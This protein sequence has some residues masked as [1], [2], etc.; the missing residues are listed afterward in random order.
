MMIDKSTLTKIGQ[1]IKPHGIS[2]EI[3][4]NFSLTLDDNFPKYFI[5]EDEGI[6]VPFFVEKY[7]L[8]GV[9]G[10]FVKF[11]GV[12]DENDVKLLCKK[13]IFFD[14]II[15]NKEAND[16]VTVNFFVGFKIIDE[17][18]GEVG[19]VQDIDQ[20]TINTLFVVDTKLI[21]MNEDFI[22]KIDK[23]KKIIFTQ[24]PDGLLEL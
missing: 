1:T 17:N 16:N 19:E 3:L 4:C 13:D 14:R 11:C 10:A 24:L 23:K 18:Y 21:P 5:L 15:E 22:L 7:R 20:S 6:F 8:T 12:D 9:F 2:G